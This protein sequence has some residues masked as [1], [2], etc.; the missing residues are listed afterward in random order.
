MAQPWQTLV[1]MLAL[2]VGDLASWV[3]WFVVLSTFGFEAQDAG[4]WAAL[5]TSV[6]LFFVIA[7]LVAHYIEEG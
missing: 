5:P 4:Q 6:F 3:I 2:F 7:A 1:F